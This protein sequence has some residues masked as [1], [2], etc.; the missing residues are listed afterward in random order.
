[1]RTFSRVHD[2][3][4]EAI[5]K[6]HRDGWLIQIRL[7]EGGFLVIAGPLSPTLELAQKRADR[8]VLSHG[9]T[10]TLECKDWTEL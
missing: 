9:H 2:T 4:T 10:C 5:L 6:E 7:K 8:E 3:G 1:V